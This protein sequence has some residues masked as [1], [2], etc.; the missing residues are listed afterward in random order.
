MFVSQMNGMMNQHQH[1]G[2]GNQPSH[3]MGMHSNGMN[4]MGMP[5]GLSNPGPMVNLSLYY[6]WL[7]LML[8]LSVRAVCIRLAWYIRAKCQ[9][10]KT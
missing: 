9:Y 5:D 2:F 1:N 10:M 6:L 8:L 7:N 3:L 4:C